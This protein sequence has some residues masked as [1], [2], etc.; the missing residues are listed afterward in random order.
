M[1]LER[2]AGELI[3]GM[4]AT[5]LLEERGFRQSYYALGDLRFL[6]HPE[7]RALATS[8]LAPETVRVLRSDLA[9]ADEI[10]LPGSTYLAHPLGRDGFSRN[11]AA[12]FYHGCT[13]ALLAIQLAAWLGC[14]EIYLLGVDLLYHPERPRFYEEG[15]PQ[16]EDVFTSVQVRNLADAGRV[17]ASFG[18]SLFGCS[19]RSLLRPYLP[20]IPFESVLES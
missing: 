7:K 16:E 1:P 17:C 11:L 15:E 18:V 2:L 19:E 9:P 20:Y 3:I 8:R 12:G 4:N 13:T 10:G 14:R 5:T 6:T